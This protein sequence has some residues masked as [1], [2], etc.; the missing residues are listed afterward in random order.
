VG[1]DRVPAGRLDRRGGADLARAPESSFHKNLDGKV[2]VRK[3]YAE[4]P[5][6]KD[7]P[8][9]G[10]RLMI[11]YPSS[12]SLRA[13]YFDNDGYVIITGSK[14]ICEGFRGVPQR[15]WRHRLSASA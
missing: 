11:V 1:P 8:A 15:K 9:F 13:M 5:A 12:G 6:T 2:V 3:N 10:M 14:A 7:G 4:Y